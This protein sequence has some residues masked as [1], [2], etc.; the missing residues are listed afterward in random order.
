MDDYIVV[1]N[2]K[3]ETPTR[4]SNSR[5]KSFPAKV[6]VHSQPKVSMV[7]QLKRQ[8]EY[9]SEDDENSDES[10]E[11]KV[12]KMPIATSSSKQQT[13]AN[14]RKINVDLEVPSEKINFNSDS[15]E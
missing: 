1:K 2:N 7:S 10:E 14:S 9:H 11:K 13:A 15:E 6:S 5:E 4:E 3:K 8:E 12:T